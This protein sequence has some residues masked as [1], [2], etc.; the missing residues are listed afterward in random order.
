M[1]ADMSVV[2]SSTDSNV[3]PV[4]SADLFALDAGADIHLDEWIAPE[5]ADENGI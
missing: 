5:L 2:S 3:I 4:E 1:V